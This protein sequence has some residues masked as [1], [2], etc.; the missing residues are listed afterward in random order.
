MKRS[1][2]VEHVVLMPMRIKTQWE[3]DKLVAVMPGWQLPP[4]GLIV[5]GESMVDALDKLDRRMRQY[6]VVPSNAKL[7]GA[8]AQEQR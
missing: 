1:D 5:E 7:S 8:P 6:W 4:A 3:G 2:V